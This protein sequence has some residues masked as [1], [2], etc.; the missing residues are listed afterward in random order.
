M[1][2]VIAGISLAAAWAA[3]GYFWVGPDVAEMLG[4]DW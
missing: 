3:I 2:G 1:F 4:L